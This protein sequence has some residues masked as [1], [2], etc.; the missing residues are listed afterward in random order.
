MLEKKRDESMN[1]LL[2]GYK[3]LKYKHRLHVELSFRQLLILSDKQT[4][5]K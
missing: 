3:E 5:A 1:N 2:P 4:F